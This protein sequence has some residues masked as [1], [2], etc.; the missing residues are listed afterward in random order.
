MEMM[1]APFGV[2]GKIQAVSALVKL[3]S[4]YVLFLLSLLVASL[5]SYEN[6]D[7]KD[8]YK[9]WVSKSIGTPPFYSPSECLISIHRQSDDVKCDSNETVMVVYDIHRKVLDSDTDHL[10]FFYLLKTINVILLYKELKIDIKDQSNNPTIHGSFPIDIH[11]GTD[12]FSFAVLIVFSLLPNG[13]TIANGVLYEVPLCAK[14]KVQLK[15]SEELVH[16]GAS[17]NLEVSASAASLCSIRSVDKG[18]L[19]QNPQDRSLLSDL[20]EEILRVQGSSRN[21]HEIMAELLGREKCPE[22]EIADTFS[23]YSIWDAYKLFLSMQLN[24]FTNT[25]MRGPVKCVKPVLRARRETNVKKPDK[26]N[27]YNS[28]LSLV[29]SQMLPVTSTSPSIS[30]VGNAY[31]SMLSLVANQMLSVTSTFT[32]IFNGDKKKPAHFTRRDFPDSWLFDLAPVGSDGHFVLNR[33][34]P[35]SVTTWVTDAF[36]LGKTG[37]AIVKDVELTTFQPYFV[38]LIVPYSVVQGE[39]FTIMAMVFSYVKKCLLIVVSLPDTENLATVNNKEQAKCV[40]EGHSHSFTWEVTTVKPKT[41]QIHVDSSFLEE[42]EKCTEDPLLIENVRRIDSVEKTVIVKPMGHEEEK[43][44]TFLLYPSASEEETHI[45][46]TLPDRLVPGSERAHIIIHGDLM[47]HIVINLDSLDIPEG[48]GES[49]FTKLWKN[50]YILGYIDSIQEPIPRKKADIVETLVK[51]YQKLTFRS[52]TGSH[53]FFP[54]D[55][56]SMWNTALVVKA[57]NEAQKWIY[58]DERHIPEAVN[59]LQT[60][61]LPN[62]CFRAE[63]NYF[64]NPQEADNEVARTAFILTA[65]LEHQRVYNGSIVEDALNCVR[66]SVDNVTSAHTQALLAYVFTLSDDRQL[67]D[68]LLKKLDETAIKQGGSMH[69][70]T[71]SN[72]ASEIQTASHILLALLSG[73]TTPTRKCLEESAKIVTWIVSNQNTK[74]GLQPYQW[75]KNPV[76][77]MRDPLARKLPSYL[78]TDTTLALQALAKYAKVINHKQGDSTVTIRSKSGFE[79]TVHVGKSN[80]FLAQSVDLPEIPGEYTVSVTGNGAVYLQSHL[81]CN[82]LPDASERSYFSLKIST[83]P[84]VCTSESQKK[85][86][87]HVDIRYTGKRKNTNMAV[88]LIEPLSGY[89]PNKYSIKKLKKYPVVKR[90]EVSAKNVYIYLDELTHTPEN[91]VFSLEQ[92]THVENLQPATV[93]V[94]DYYF[95]DEHAVVEYNAPCSAGL[96]KTEN[97]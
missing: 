27:I 70:E 24:V 85:F 79:R 91:F 18:Y 90:A 22:N 87:V 55:T 48:Y 15:F 46:L 1:S 52:D 2:P 59:W 41:L 72:H 67:R 56:S 76:V 96:K 29:A 19:L 82:L 80:S 54:S 20:R 88:I 65:I 6:F 13:E 78:Y 17:V 81:L 31:N 93:T 28:M 33:T 69:W 89:V 86:N 60:I 14:E 40:C 8:K 45:T 44:Q 95:A 5:A 84:S 7:E 26:V 50:A 43:I 42:D 53:G 71:N 68:R 30:N 57:Y 58:I 11:I 92:E 74:L 37:F 9:R 38:D 49:N 36:C 66:K 64:N 4:V 83:E 21:P 77:Q 34:T 23:L 16:P 73:K 63:G 51:A 75:R 32:S 25:Q 10:H 97:H 3:W 35:D 62:G 47:T 61:Q 94:Y 39:K 12:M